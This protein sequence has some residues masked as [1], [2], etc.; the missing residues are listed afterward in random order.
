[1]SFE[2]KAYESLSNMALKKLLTEGG[3]SESAH[4]ALLA[5]LK[6][7]GIDPDAVTAEYQANQPK[8]PPPDTKPTPA[9]AAAMAALAGAPGSARVQPVKLVSVDIPFMDLVNLAIKI[10]LA[11][12]PAGIIVGIIYFI[13]AA[14][15]WGALR[16]AAS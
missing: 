5:E 4:N 3:L 9:R 14:L 1:M 16:G 6:R 13:F 11:L 7:R 2:S 12:I 15:F 8:E 10:S